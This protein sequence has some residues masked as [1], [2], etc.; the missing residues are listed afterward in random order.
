VLDPF[1]GAGTTAMIAARLR[2]RCISVELNPEYIDMA[3]KRIKQDI[4]ASASLWE[5]TRASNS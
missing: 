1:G 4:L 3:K 5:K 2:R